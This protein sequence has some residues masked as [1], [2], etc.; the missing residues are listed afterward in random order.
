MNWVQGTGDP[1]RMHWVYQMDKEQWG[2]H[3]D[4]RT[5]AMWVDVEYGTVL[6]MLSDGGWR[7]TK[8]GE[9]YPARYRVFELVGTDVA[10]RTDGFFSGLAHGGHFDERQVGAG[11]YQAVR[12]D[13][14]EAIERKLE[15]SAARA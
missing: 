5:G 8:N 4:D 6:A 15:V 7:M 1:W 3:E 12:R 11:R 14:V 13:C 2:L 10:E 9:P